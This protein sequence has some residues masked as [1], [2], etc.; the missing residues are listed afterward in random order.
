ME[1]LT[2]F[3]DQAV[4]LPLAAAIGLALALS[5]WWRGCA[6][7]IVVVGGVLGTMGVLKI[8][9]F[10]CS[11]LLGGT[12][13]HSPSGH[14]ASAAVI[15]GGALILFLRG[16]VPVAVLA[17][18]PVSLAVLFGISRLAVHAHSIAE[19]VVGGFIGLAGAAMLAMLA[20]PRPR[21]PGWP[22]A[23]AAA[24]ILIGLHGLRLHAESAL[25]SFTLFSWLP[26]P[27]ICRT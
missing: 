9:F 6:A 3:A 1:F 22:A 27:A 23:V 17:A 14:T 4:M 21:V 5:G 11:S 7:W 8:A 19:V 26:L 20:G 12:G 13:I 25:H 18:I 16:R 24:A 15:M 2:D 10:A